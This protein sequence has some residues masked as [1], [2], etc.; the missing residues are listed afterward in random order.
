MTNFKA[1]SKFEIFE[2]N[3]IN[4]I[5]AIDNLLYFF[6]SM[7]KSSLENVQASAKPNQHHYSRWLIASNI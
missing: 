3:M 5:S 7:N 2:R 4:V 1:S 6:G